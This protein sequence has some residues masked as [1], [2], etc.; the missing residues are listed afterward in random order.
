MFAWLA[1]TF[2]YP[3]TSICQAFLV[4]QAILLDKEQAIKT[5]QVAKLQAQLDLDQ[6]N[7]VEV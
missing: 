3:Y 1:K 4:D 2:D 5:E 6:L 7:S